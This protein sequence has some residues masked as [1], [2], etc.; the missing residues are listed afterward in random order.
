MPW[1]DL[2]QELDE[3]FS[4]TRDMRPVVWRT[5]EGMTVATPPS[6]YAQRRRQRMLK[7]G[8]CYCGKAPLA[9]GRK[10]CDP[11][12][13]ACRDRHKKQVADGIAK[14]AKRAWRA[15]N[16]AHGLCI[17]GAEK[18]PERWA[19]RRCLDADNARTKR[20][21]RARKATRIARGTHA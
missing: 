1:V 3:L 2:E 11:C 5:R 9:P 6:V 18:V 14:L 15:T 16:K 12:L 4:E 19:C 20:R 13:V 17:C 21:Y 10:S 8:L 7:A